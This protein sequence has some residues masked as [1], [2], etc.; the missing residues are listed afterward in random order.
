[1]NSQMAAIVGVEIELTELKGK[2]KLSQNRDDKDREGVEAALAASGDQPE[3]LELMQG[4]KE[5][6][7]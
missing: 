7:A 6:G 2:F 3:A 4:L 5:P 1:M